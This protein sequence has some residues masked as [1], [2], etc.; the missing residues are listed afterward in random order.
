MSASDIIAEV[1]AA[2]AEVGADAGSGA[3]LTVTIIR[4]SAAVNEPQIPWANPAYPVNATTQYTVNAL[5]TGIKSFYQAGLV[6]R[7]A[8]V[9]MIEAGVVVPTQADQITV[10]GVTHQIQR[11]NPVAPAGID[12]FYK[13]E[14]SE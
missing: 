3:A 11:V 2:L 5:D 4:A 7:T 12:L 6:I 14:I 13:V 9:I 10:R 1:A 8:R